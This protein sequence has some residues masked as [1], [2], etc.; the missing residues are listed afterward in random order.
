MRFNAYDDVHN[1]T[2]I[3]PQ[4]ISGS[5]AVNG[6]SVDTQGYDNAKIASLPSSG[7]PEIPDVGSQNVDQS[8]N[9]ARPQL[10]FPLLSIPHDCPS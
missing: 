9:C 10:S 5:S 8:W 1:S 6:T 2:S 7:S 3:V 4:S